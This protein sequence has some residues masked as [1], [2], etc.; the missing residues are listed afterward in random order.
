MYEHINCSTNSKRLC[1]HF[2]VGLKWRG[3]GRVPLCAHG[4]ATARCLPCMLLRTSKVSSVEMIILYQDSTHL[5]CVL[6]FP[7]VFHAL[8]GH[9]L[10]AY[11]KSQVQVNCLL[12][13]GLS[14]LYLSQLQC[15][16]CCEYCH[17]VVV[18]PNKMVWAAHQTL[19]LP[20]ND[21]SI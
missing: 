10:L 5:P 16:S 3:S 9:S 14:T 1:A 6:C 12:C 15:V 7:Y 17:H 19:F 21:V 2:I 18:D 13:V 4:A 8:V 11:P 20:R